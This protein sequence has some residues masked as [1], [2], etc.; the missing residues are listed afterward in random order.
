[1]RSVTYLQPGERRGC[2]GCHEP[3]NVAPPSRPL[4]AL[5]RGPSRIEPGP[6]GTRPFSYPRLVQ[7]VLERNC[8]RCHD[9]SEGPEKS[10]LALT[11]QPAGTFSRSYESLRPYVRWYEWG[12]ASITQVV[13]HPGRV[14]ADNSPLMDV[15]VD[16]TH[17]GAVKLSEADRRRLCI[18][19]DGNAP[20]Y[21]TYTAEEQQ[22]QRNARPVAP[23]HLQ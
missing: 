19:L 15:L 1:M 16:S 9:G 11:G 5:R 6:D 3:T 8:V 10:S 2:I 14:G 23:P 12:G 20:F 13:T 4:L 17:R 7:P 21:G 22:A 18:W